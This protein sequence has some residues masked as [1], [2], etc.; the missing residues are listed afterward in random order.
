ML[1]GFYL[2][3]QNYHI[4]T[5]TSRVASKLRNDTRGFCFPERKR[6]YRRKTYDWK[7][8]GDSGDQDVW[9]GIQDAANPVE[10]EPIIAAVLVS[11]Y[12]EELYGRKGDATVRKVVAL[13]VAVWVEGLPIAVVADEMGWNYWAAQKTLMRAAN[14]IR[15]QVDAETLVA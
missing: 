1:S 10:Q 9:N 5:R 7:V 15:H 2:A 14:Y 6:A 8:I 11:R 3:V 4:E 12:I 13:A